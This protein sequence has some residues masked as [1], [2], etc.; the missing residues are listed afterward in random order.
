TGE[1]SYELSVPADR[2]TDFFERIWQA[3][4]AH[5]IG[6]F[7]VESLTILRLEKGFF[8]VG[9][10]T[11][12]S[13]NPFDIG[14]GGIVAN[15]KGDFI[16]ARSLQRAEDKR[17][18]RRQLIGVETD[19]RSAT[20]LAGAHIVT[21]NGTERRSEGFVT[22]AC[23]SP[24]LGKTIGLGLLERGAE[25]KGETVQLFDDEQVVRARV[26][27]TCFYDPDGERMRG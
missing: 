26:V 27:D 22:S 14:F 25:R 15:K 6:M 10:E 2:A 11:D 4:Q 16:G 7:G 13:T 24:T 8:E 21:G 9:V 12:G 1:Q 23:M 18:D 3:G 19:D 17:V 5:D 20:V